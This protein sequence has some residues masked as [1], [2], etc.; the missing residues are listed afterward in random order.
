MICYKVTHKYKLHDH[1]ELK[2]IGIYSSKA[3]AEDAIKSLIDKDGFREIKEGF[4]IKTT[5]R[6]SKPKLIDQTFWTEGF[7]THTY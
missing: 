1:I 6:F 4:L 5:V 3:N 2:D 7:V